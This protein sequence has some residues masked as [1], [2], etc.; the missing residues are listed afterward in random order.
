MPPKKIFVKYYFLGFLIDFVSTPVISAYTSAASFTIGCNQIK[1][2]LGLKITQKSEL[3]GS[4]SKSFFA[5]LECRLRDY[6]KDGGPKNLK[7]E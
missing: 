6:R 4:A 3:P 2:L 7:A 1:S 5:R